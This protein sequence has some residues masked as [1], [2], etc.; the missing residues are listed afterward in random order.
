MPDAIITLPAQA[1]RG[2]ACRC[3]PG[4]ARRKTHAAVSG[5]GMRGRAFSIFRPPTGGTR[6]SS[7]V[8]MN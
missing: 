4:R 2:S 5:P 1:L 3:S 8:S 7:A 6:R